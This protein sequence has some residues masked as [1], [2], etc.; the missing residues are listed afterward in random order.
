MNPT[1]PDEPQ[2]QRFL[3]RFLAGEPAAARTVLRWARETAHFRGFGLSAEEREDVAQDALAQLWSLGSRPGF[4]LR[5]GV[6]AIL[7]TI[8]SARCIDR[9]RRRRPTSEVDDALPDPAPDVA[10]RFATED[11]RERLRRALIELDAPCREIVRLRFFEELDYATLAA[12]EGR[13]ESTL[14]VRLFHCLRR[15]RR[16]LQQARP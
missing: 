15:L 2:E 9:V 12:R 13:S 14:R 8:V 10:E 3:R 1:S 16:R 5:R 6:R 7:R 11:E 4:E